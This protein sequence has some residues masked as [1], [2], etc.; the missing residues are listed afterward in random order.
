MDSA[1]AA[2]AAYQAEHPGAAQ[3]ASRA[4]AAH[5]NLTTAIG[6]ANTALDEDPTNPDLALLLAQLYAADRRY[7]AALEVLDASQTANPG[8]V[9][10][11][12]AQQRIYSA[13]L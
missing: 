11:K 8:D 1:E 7:Q 9:R 10:L 4:Y 13:A 5:G 3:Q 6:W 2:Q 12:Q